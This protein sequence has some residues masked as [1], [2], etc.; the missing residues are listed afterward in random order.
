MNKYVLFLPYDSIVD[1]Y[2]W[3]TYKYSFIKSDTIFSLLLTEK[4][5]LIPRVSLSDLANDSSVS[6]ECL[7]AILDTSS[8]PSSNGLSLKT[9]IAEANDDS[10]YSIVLE[11]MKDVCIKIF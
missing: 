10:L 11:T 8:K 2:Y 7:K 4:N 9:Y 3:L 5:H 6:S 1:N